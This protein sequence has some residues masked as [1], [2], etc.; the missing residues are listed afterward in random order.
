MKVG[1]VGLL[2]CC[3][4][5]W[6]VREKLPSLS[7]EHNS[8]EICHLHIKMVNN[9]VN[10]YMIWLFWITNMYRKHSKI[11]HLQYF[12]SNFYRGKGRLTCYSIRDF[13]TLNCQCKLNSFLN[14]SLQN[15]S[16]LHFSNVYISRYHKLNRSQDC[17]CSFN[18]SDCSRFAEVDKSKCNT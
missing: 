18:D 11:K 9:Y 15:D 3:Y 16:I 6:T 14:E 13:S 10:N 17:R 12:T 5:R 2:N 8:W 1:G 4:D 7:A